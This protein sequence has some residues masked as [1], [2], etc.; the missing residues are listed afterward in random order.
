MGISQG[1]KQIDRTRM[2]RQWRVRPSPSP[3][4]AWLATSAPLSVQV[5]FV[6]L[7][8]CPVSP[9]RIQCHDEISIFISASTGCCHLTAPQSAANTLVKSYI[10]LH[11]QSHLDTSLFFGLLLLL[12]LHLL[13]PSVLGLCCLCLG[14]AIILTSSQCTSTTLQCSSCVLA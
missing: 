4:S 5:S 2:S 12:L 7:P 6:L 14:P 1:R 9:A 8:L 11:G 10:G 3:S 13:H